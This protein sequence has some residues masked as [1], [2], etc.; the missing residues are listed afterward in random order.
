MIASVHRKTSITC[1][2]KMNEYKILQRGRFLVLY[3]YIR[4]IRWFK[5]HE[6]VTYT[7]ISDLRFLDNIEILSE[8]WKGPISIAL[9][10]PGTDF[11][12]ALESIKYLYKC[13]SYLIPVYVT[14]HIYFEDTHR[15]KYIPKPAHVFDNM[16]V[17]CELP[18]WQILADTQLYRIQ[19]NLFFPIN[20]GR[21]IARNAATTHYIL[22]SD[23]ELYPSAN[24]ISQFLDMI[25]SG[26]ASL[27]TRTPA[28]FVL[29]PFE[30]KENV[31]PPILKRELVS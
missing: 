6:S 18:P 22:A 31:Q 26:N 25:E 20:I 11:E 28:V 9:Y 19:K 23:I 2:D 30:I 29:P 3:N 27:R 5:C 16:N 17:S 13:S 14:F 21:N 24:I 15:P 7:T 12:Y 8:R 1:F 4:A 10:T